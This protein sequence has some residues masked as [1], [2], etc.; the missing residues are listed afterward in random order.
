MNHKITI[1]P[2]SYLETYVFP[3]NSEIFWGKVI[4][5]FLDNPSKSAK[6]SSKPAKVVT[7]IVFRMRKSISWNYL[8]TEKKETLLKFCDWRVTACHS[9]PIT[10]RTSCS[11]LF[12]SFHPKSAP[13]LTRGC[14]PEGLRES[15][16]TGLFLIYRYTAAVS[17]AR[18]PQA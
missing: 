18:M 6:F 14:A 11:N 7:R 3:G 16:P 8:D 13:I 10:Y 4:R 17:P 12:R 9:L 15:G 1:C 2:F 5:H